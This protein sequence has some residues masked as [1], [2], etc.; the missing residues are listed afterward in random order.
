MMASDVD[1]TAPSSSRMKAKRGSS[2][3]HIGAYRF[4]A[5]LGNGSMADVYLAVRTGPVGTGFAKLAVIKRVRA[6][7][8]EDS[9]FITMFMDEARICSRLSHPN[10]VQ[11]LELGDA[12]GEYFI[13]ME[14]LDG[15]PLVKITH[16]IERAKLDVPRDSFVGVISDVLA[17]LHYAHDLADFDGQPLAIVHRDVTPQNV[18]VTYHGEVK[19]V[20]F[21]IARAAGRA[22]QTRPGMVKG[23]LRYMSPEQARGE[24]LDRRTDVFAAGVMLWHAATGRSPFAGIHEEQAMVDLASG[25]YPKSPRAA[26]EDVPPELDRICARAVAFDRDD[27]YATA[28]EMKADIDAYLGSRASEARRALVEAMQTLF[29]HDREKIRKVMEGA[30]P[31][32]AL[33]VQAPLLIARPRKPS[34]KRTSAPR[35]T[36]RTSKSRSSSRARGQ[37]ARAPSRPAWTRYATIAALAITAIGGF[38]FALTYDPPRAQNAPSALVADRTG[39]ASPV[40]ALAPSG[41]ALPAVADGAA[42][43]AEEADNAVATGAPATSTSS[44]YEPLQGDSS[45]PEGAHL[46]IDPSDPW[47]RR[48]AR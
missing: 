41:R 48:P 29:A 26:G 10:V 34:S 3:T 32:I 31:E 6:H 39:F 17:G 1:G 8:I 23:K 45:S 47:P 12:D 28:E 4:L 44:A 11:T 16:K 33:N 43:G 2:E 9:D 7:L 5:R 36:P 25:L 22:S 40:V 14:H 13:A 20:D 42:A 18:F 35:S 27:R 24:E 15:Q 30:V 37:A 21:G 38:T 19:V 46:N